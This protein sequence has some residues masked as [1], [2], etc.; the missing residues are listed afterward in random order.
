MVYGTDTG[1]LTDYDQGEEF[2]QLAKAGFSFR[3]VLAMLTTAPV[4]LF[5]LSQNEGKVMLGMRGDL[6]IL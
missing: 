3:D 6:T 2:R 1:L 4:G 5:H